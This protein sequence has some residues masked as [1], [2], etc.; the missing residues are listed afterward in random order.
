MAPPEPYP[1]IRAVIFDC[2]GTLVDSEVSGLDVLHQLAGLHGAAFTR[3]EA[4]AL[5]RGKRM[6]GCVE[7][8][9]QRLPRRPDGFN[10]RFTTAVRQAMARRFR[11]SLEPMPG[12]LALVMSNTSLP[13]LNCTFTWPPR[14]SLPNRMSSARGFLMCSWMTRASG[15]AP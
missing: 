13:S 12:A 4:H 8:I 2:D 1:S 14:I 6:A 11:E 7:A 5:F 15:R 9:A 10:D 3:E